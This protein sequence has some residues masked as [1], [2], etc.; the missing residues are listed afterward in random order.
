MINF[1]D[2]AMEEEKASNGW[3]VH[4]SQEQHYTFREKLVSNKYPG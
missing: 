4:R 2:Q 1:G 3:I